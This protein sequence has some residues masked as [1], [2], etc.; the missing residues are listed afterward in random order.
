LLLKHQAANVDPAL[1][2][3]LIRL[4]GFLPQDVKNYSQVVDPE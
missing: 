3:Y 1:I 4:V 2:G